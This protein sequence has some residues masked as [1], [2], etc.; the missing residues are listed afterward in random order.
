MII[1][2]C[3]KDKAITFNGEKLEVV[4]SYKYLSL[5]FD[6]CYSWNICVEKWVMEGTWIQSNICKINVDKLNYGVGN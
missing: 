3:N 6:C 5:E 4:P 1:V 2:T